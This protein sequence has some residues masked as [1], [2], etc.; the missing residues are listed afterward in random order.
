MSRSSEDPATVGCTRRAEEDKYRRLMGDCKHRLLNTTKTREMVEETQTA[1]R[2]SQIER[3]LLRWC[4]HTNSQVSLI[5]VSA[6]D[7]YFN[8][9][10]SQ[11][12]Q[13]QLCR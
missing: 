5:P 10:H 13:L 3:G 7:S 9:T 6:H 1:P 4:T 8:N 11:Q 12:P 2:A